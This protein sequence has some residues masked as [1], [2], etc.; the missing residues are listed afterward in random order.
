MKISEV[1]RSLQSFAFCK[2]DFM[3][4]PDG[5]IFFTTNGIIVAPSTALKA[6]HPHTTKKFSKVFN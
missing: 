5:T 1:C 3:C 2:K 4:V 6:R